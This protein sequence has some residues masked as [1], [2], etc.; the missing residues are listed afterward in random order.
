MGTVTEIDSRMLGAKVK[1][2]GGGSKRVRTA[3]VCVESASQ[4]GKALKCK[5]WNTPVHPALRTRKH[6]VQVSSSYTPTKFK[7]SDLTTLIFL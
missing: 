6:R 5:C 7:A 2:W 3:E 4:S 1:G